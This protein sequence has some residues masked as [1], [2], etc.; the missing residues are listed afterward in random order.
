[1]SCLFQCLAELGTIVEE[2]FNGD[3]F[4]VQYMD[5]NIHIVVK[6][7]LYRVWLH[8]VYLIMCRYVIWI[9]L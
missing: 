9:C 3:M 8:T 2:L 1:M 7:A 5:A 4:R 6:E